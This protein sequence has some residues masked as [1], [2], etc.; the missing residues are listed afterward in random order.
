LNHTRAENNLI[1]KRCPINSNQHTTGT[2]FPRKIFS[3]FLFLTNL[4]TCISLLSPVYSNFDGR[5][6]KINNLSMLFLTLIPLTFDRH[7]KNVKTTN[8][9][10]EERRKNQIVICDVTNLACLKQILKFHNINSRRLMFV[11]LCLP[12]LNRPP[13]LA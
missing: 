6:P 10:L 7:R 4:F 13:A 5:P 11:M 8:G 9:L 3:L 12:K 2:H 1:V